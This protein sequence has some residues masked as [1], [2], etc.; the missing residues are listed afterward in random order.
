LIKE[1]N[2][3]VLA[4]SCP[5][6][7][8]TTREDIKQVINNIYKQFKEAKNNFLTMLSNYEKYDLWDKDISYQLNAEGLTLKQIDTAV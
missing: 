2:L 4:S 7:K 3:P 6:D 1:E 5:S 8:I